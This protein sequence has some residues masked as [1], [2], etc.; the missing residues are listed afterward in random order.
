MSSPPDGISKHYTTRQ[1]SVLLRK[2]TQS[3]ALLKLAL[4]TNERQLVRKRIKK[5]MYVRISAMPYKL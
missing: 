3:I 1:L 4:H 5:I 2:L